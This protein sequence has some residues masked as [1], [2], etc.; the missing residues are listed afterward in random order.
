MDFNEYLEKERVLSEKLE[1]EPT[2]ENYDALYDFQTEY[3]ESV[4]KRLTPT[5]DTEEKQI[6]LSILD[7]A[8]HKSESGSVVQEVDT[9]EQA[10][11]VYDVLWDIAGDYMLD[12]PQIY[13][14]RN[15]KWTISCM[16]GGAFVPGW[17]GL[18][19]VA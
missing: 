9:K 17:D 1:N 12:A 19:E 11:A 15:G 18:P 4:I 8:V 5:A 6:A 10:D 13:K 14:E 3:M 7:Y 2:Q 16:F